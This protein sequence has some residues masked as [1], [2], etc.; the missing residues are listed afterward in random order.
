LDIIRKIF[1]QIRKVFFQI[2]RFFL[3]SIETFVQFII[4]LHKLAMKEVFA[5]QVGFFY[6]SF[7]T[8]FPQISSYITT[9][10]LISPHWFPQLIWICIVVSLCCMQSKPKAKTPISCC[11][12]DAPIDNCDNR[13]KDRSNINSIRNNTTMTRQNRETEQ[14]IVK[15]L[16][17]RK[18]GANAKGSLSPLFTDSIT[19][20]HLFVA[21]DAAVAKFPP[22]LR[23]A[24]FSDFNDETKT[25]NHLL[26]DTSSA[27]TCYYLISK[28]P[29]E[30]LRS[31]CFLLVILWAF[32]TVSNNSS[33]LG[34]IQELTRSEQV[35]LGFTL[36]VI[37]LG[38]SCSPIAWIS[39]S[40]QIFIITLFHNLI[41]QQHHIFL[42]EHFLMTFGMATLHLIHKFSI[43]YALAEEREQAKG[44]KS[45][46]IQETAGA[47]ATS[48]YQTK[49][50][51]VWELLGI[52]AVAVIEFAKI[53]YR[54]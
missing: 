11:Q 35:L 38:Y 18:N 37:K 9:D 17:G 53:I 32:D 26:E 10:V 3:F 16:S 5:N 40:V 44:G 4:L 13:R 14:L 7:R 52:S 36:A 47:T 33:S 54:S 6:Y 20:N 12:K 25:D 2:S 46:A 24:L 15:I 8:S 48:Q 49:T 30:I 41:G 27:Y 43:E 50:E 39:W 45:S 29:K 31:F 23:A 21:G 42:L 28:L 34:I 19:S 51:G 1:D 22:S